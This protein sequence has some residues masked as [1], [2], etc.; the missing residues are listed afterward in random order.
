MP[1]PDYP[2]EPHR[3]P[4]IYAPNEALPEPGKKEPVFKKGG[5]LILA[6]AIASLC[7]S[8]WFKESGLSAQLHAWVGHVTFGEETAKPA[9]KPGEST[10]INGV[11][12]KRIN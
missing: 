2:L 6:G 1:E 10:E 5:I 3:R 11:K 4:D 7:F 9:L 12:I 8:V